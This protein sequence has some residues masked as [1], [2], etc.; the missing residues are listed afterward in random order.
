MIGFIFIFQGDILHVI[1]Q[2][3]ANWW[4][5]FREGE[6]DQTLAGLIPSRSFQQQ[7][8][9]ERERIEPNEEKNRTDWHFL[10]SFPFFLVSLRQ[11][12]R[13]AVKQAMVIDTMENEITSSRPGKAGTLLCARKQHKKKKRASF[14]S[15][16]GKG[17]FVF[18]RLV[19]KDI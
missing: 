11:S 8:V 9:G 2:D 17:D 12:R 18:L 4:Q 3:D 13:E 15:N 1:S 7:W 14:R 16:Y 6:E 5:A 19:K 10:L